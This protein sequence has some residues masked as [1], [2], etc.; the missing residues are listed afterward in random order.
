MF[1]LFKV[2]L[3]TLLIVCA[4][5]TPSSRGCGDTFVSREQENN[6][7]DV[8]TEKSFVQSRVLGNCCLV[9][10]MAALPGN[11]ELLHRVLPSNFTKSQ[12]NLQFNIYR[13]G[14]LHR[15]EVD[16]K[17]LPT[18]E[19]GSELVYS[20]SANGDMVG[21]LLEKALID[22]HFGGDYESS[23]PTCPSTVLASF[24]NGYYEDFPIVSH[25]YGFKI[26]D[27]VKH[28]LKSN[29]PMVVQF[30]GAPG[31]FEEHCYTLLDVKNGT[32]KLYNPHGSYLQ[33]TESDF[34]EYLQSLDIAYYKNKI[35]RMPQVEASFEFKETWPALQQHEKIRFVGYDLFID[36]NDTEVLLNFLAKNATLLRDPSD[37]YPK[38]FILAVDN[39]KGEESRRIV[40]NSVVRGFRKPNL[41]QIV[42]FT[43]SLRARLNS[44]RYKVVVALSTCCSFDNSA[45]IEEHLRDGRGEFL[46]RLAA[47]KRCSVSKPPAKETEMVEEVLN[48]LI[49]RK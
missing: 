17:S 1:K 24:T 25:N 5:L 8:I 36:E 13:A 47:S 20:S 23:E 38:F 45:S 28:G 6:F 18:K 29:S 34:Y 35:F 41:K 30:A 37:V 7:D 43:C 22:V 16:A 9:A 44:G 21:P 3:L 15:V 27:V 26:S 49:A 12:K 10:G 14:E 33:M 11:A 48:D 40:R 42:S 2:K 4:F 31:L 32:V 19:G 46:F 39:K